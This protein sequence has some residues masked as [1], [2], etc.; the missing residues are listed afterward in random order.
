MSWHPPTKQV[1]TLS[2]LCCL[3]LEQEGSEFSGNLFYSAV[4]PRILNLLRPVESRATMLPAAEVDLQPKATSS[5]WWYWPEYKAKWPRPW[6]STGVVYAD[7]HLG[8][9]TINQH[10]TKSPNTVL[11]INLVSFFP[12]T[13]VLLL[14]SVQSWRT[15][16]EGYLLAN[17]AA[18]KLGFSG[19]SKPN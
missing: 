15:D 2:V 13:G 17:Q 11:G 4:L 18:T 6:V 5:H 7:I 12:V 9:G 16:G 19:V 8:T 3:G 1:I 14:L 10:S